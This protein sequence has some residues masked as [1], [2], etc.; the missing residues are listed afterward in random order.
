MKFKMEATAGLRLTLDPMAMGKCFK[1][2]LLWNHLDDWK[3]TAQECSLDGPL[4][5]LGFLFQYKMEDG[6]H[7]MS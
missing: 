6:C 4:Q 2:L 3:Q 5:T 1:T 7:H